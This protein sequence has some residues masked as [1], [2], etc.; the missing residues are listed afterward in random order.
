MDISH[1]RHDFDHHSP[2]DI[3]QLPNN[4]HS[5]FEEW[6]NVAREYQ[7]A[8]PNGFV[9]STTN[10]ERRIRS[11]TV[12]LKYFDETGYVFFTNYGS[13]KAKDIAE[14]NQVSVCFPWYALERQVMIEG[15]AEKISHMESLKYFSSRPRNSQIG[16]WVSEQSQIISSRAV[17][18]DKVKQLTEHFFDKDIP[19]PEFWGGYRIIPERFEFWQGQPSRL[20]DRIEYAIK[21]GVWQRSRLSP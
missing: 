17:L 19:L 18:M 12:L 15:R 3:K 7:I 8:E 10:A 2:I 21:E 1:L 16:A 11:R 5:L 9:L 13:Q 6:F 20:H 4:P 14:N